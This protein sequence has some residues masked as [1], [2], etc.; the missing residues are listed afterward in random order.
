MEVSTEKFRLKTDNNR[1][2]KNLSNDN[3][4]YNQKIQNEINPIY[5]FC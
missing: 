2:S 5:N 4:T 1:Y 3:L